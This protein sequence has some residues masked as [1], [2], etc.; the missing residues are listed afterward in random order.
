M[1]N[2][3]SFSAIQCTVYEKSSQVLFKEQTGS[4]CTSSPSLTSLPSHLFTLQG[5][6]RAPRSELACRTQGAAS[7]WTPAALPDTLSRGKER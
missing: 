3:H 5:K 6:G 2:I 4:H 7:S 1:E